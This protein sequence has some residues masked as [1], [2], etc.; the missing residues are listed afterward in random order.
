MS[1]QTN[2]KTWMNILGKYILPHLASIQIENINWNYKL[3][4]ELTPE[5][6]PGLGGFR[7]KFY[8]IFKDQIIPTLLNCAK[9]RKTS[10]V[11]LWNITLI[12]K[13]ELY[14]KGQKT[15]DLFMNINAKF[16]LKYEQIES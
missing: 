10:S 1:F 12:Q 4:K 6:A 13:P 7:G 3:I 14:C 8:Q 15:S 11:S 16:E 9:R 2:L 5:Q